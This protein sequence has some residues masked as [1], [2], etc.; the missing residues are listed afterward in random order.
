MQRPRNSQNKKLIF[1]YI[2]SI[3]RKKR[4]SDNGPL[5]HQTHSIP[6]P[7]DFVDGAELMLVQ[8]VSVPLYHLHGFMPEDVRQGAKITPTHEQIAGRRV[9]KVMHPKVLNPC[10]LDGIL[11]RRSKRKIGLSQDTLRD[12]R[13]KED[14]SVG[15]NG[16]LFQG[17]DDLAGHGDALGC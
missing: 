14:K 15:F 1:N 13:G 8:K 16:H 17:F 3:R 9:A 6:K 5:Y 4:A 10:P 11:K 7:P 12:R 2:I